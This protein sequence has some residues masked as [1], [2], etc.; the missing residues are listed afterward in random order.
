[1]RNQASLDLMNFKPP[2]LP[3]LFDGN[4]TLNHQI[5]V[6]DVAISFAGAG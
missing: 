6:D 4:P 5:V 1:M 3:D 2:F